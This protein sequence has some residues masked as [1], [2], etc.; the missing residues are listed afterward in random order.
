[1][2]EHMIGK[3]KYFNILKSYNV[4]NDPD[5]RLK[6]KITN[7]GL[8]FITTKLLEKLSIYNRE[9]DIRYYRKKGSEKLP[10]FLYAVRTACYCFDKNNNISTNQKQLI[11]FIINQIYNLIIKDKKLIYGKKIYINEDLNIRYIVKN[12]IGIM[13]FF[14][15]LK[16]EDI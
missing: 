9:I 11:T 12:N 6:V 14:T 3:Q 16:T 13:K 7:I 15:K 5:Q 10:E 1:M 2:R 4:E 8:K